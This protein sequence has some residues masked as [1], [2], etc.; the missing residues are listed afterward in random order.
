MNELERR[1]DD[2]P[3]PG[4]GADADADAAH[5]ACP[6][7]P[8][9]LT[10]PVPIA[11]LYREH[12]QFVWRSLRRLGVRASSIDDAVQDVFLVAHRKLA[13]FE[14]RASHRGWL[15]AIAA[16]V[17]AE[18]RRRD[19]RLRLDEDLSS[20]PAHPDN[21][22]E[23]R[24]R[25]QLLDQLLATLSVPQREV[26]IMAEVE[27]FSAPEIAEA[28]GEKLNTIYSRL[29]LG[30]HRFERALARTRQ[31]HDERTVTR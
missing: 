14:G 27:G 17:A 6:Q 16:R 8:R 25:V 12:F 26:F 18:H 28:L 21:S 20:V 15:F 2:A 30:R 19:G 5:D 22:L 3:R 11:T 1:L 29:R 13:S 31:P 23:N 24:R 9:P 7:A 10:A 4:A